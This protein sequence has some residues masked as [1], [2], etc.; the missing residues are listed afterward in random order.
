ME[1]TESGIYSMRVRFRFSLVR[2]H[3]KEIKVFKAKHCSDLGVCLCV[4]K[5]MRKREREKK[6]VI[7][8][9]KEK[10][11]I[12]SKSLQAQLRHCLDLKAVI[13]TMGLPLAILGLHLIIY[14]FWPR[15]LHMQSNLH[16]RNLQ[17]NSFS[18][19]CFLLQF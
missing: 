2:I 15:K 6:K 16:I 9:K 5:D 3:L 14:V 18:H 8:I 17:G 4:W 10:G 12:R 7:M 13:M 11:L 1:P 19:T